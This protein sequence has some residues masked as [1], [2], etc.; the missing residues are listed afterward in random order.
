M[1]QI[2]R[3]SFR[4][5]FHHGLRRLF[6]VLPAPAR[7]EIY[8]RMVD[9]DPDPDAR[10]QLKIAETREELEDCFKILHDAYVA[11]GFMKPEPS[12]MRITPYH[13]LPT[14]TTL[15]AKYD[16]RV[17]GTISM[18]RE[19]VF[20]FPLQSVFD[21]EHVRAQ[22]GQIAEISA[23]AVHPDFRK[24]G[25]AI[26]FPLM[27]F[28]HEYCTEFF[29]TRHLVIAVNPERI[30]LYEALLYFQ[31][32]QET[33]VD[34][35]DFA[36]GAPAVGATLDLKHASD[37]FRAGYRGRA[38]RKNLH[39][40]FFQLKLENIQLPRR[41]YFTTNDPVMTPAL[42]DHFFNKKSKVF[43]ELDDRKKALLWSIYGLVEYRS[44]LPMLRG[45]AVAGHPL[46]QHQRYSIRC[47]GVV[48][49]DTPEGKRPF[50]LHVIE[51]SL[52]GFQAEC[53]L[54][55]ELGQSGQAT[56][57]LGKSEHSTVTVSAVRRRETEAGVFIG[58]RLDEPD[59]IWRQCVAALEVGQT[60]DDLM[61]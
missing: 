56:I 24:T 48:T 13:A 4:K 16:G 6:G 51:V 3:S 27:K 59:R 30:E 57:E 34:N 54:D 43:E 26:L 21:L 35:Y 17:V 40:Y 36:N 42:L 33:V 11:S 39:K 49:F 31:R 46:R 61:Q 15:C 9:C 47:P 53:K 38:A 29:D 25:G 2:Q 45:D 20:G 5:K 50:V 60:S 18:I 52:S 14:T 23:L 37:V 12:G 19:G 8:R 1:T 10:L 32:L 55:L 22:G 44:V 28:M 58:F 7:F 41:R